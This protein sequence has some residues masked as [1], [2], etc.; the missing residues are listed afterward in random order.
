VPETNGSV[1][2]TAPINQRFYNP[3]GN[4]A[5]LISIKKHSPSYVHSDTGCHF[6]SS[7]LFLQSRCYNNG[8]YYK[9]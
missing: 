9:S 2:F 8:L 4:E 3:F 7:H 1:Y 5:K 6:R